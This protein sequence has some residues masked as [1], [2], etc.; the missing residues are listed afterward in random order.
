MNKYSAIKTECEHGHTHDSKMEAKRCDE[1]H[2]LQ[3]AGRIERLEQQPVFNCSVDGRKICDYRADFAYFTVGETPSDCRIVE[4]VK[5]ML[6]PVYR[7]KKKIV[8]AIHPGVVITEW[9][10]RKRKKRKS[11]K[12]KEK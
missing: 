9:P 6:T 10:V 4:D 11:A 8:E 12:R 5:G 3:R 1:L 2:V 7:L